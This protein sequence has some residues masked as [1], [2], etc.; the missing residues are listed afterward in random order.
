MIRTILG[1]SA[2]VTDKFRAAKPVKMS[3]LILLVELDMV[4]LCRW[5][6]VYTRL[7]NSFMN[8]GAE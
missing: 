4:I 3:L 6:T 2:A 5:K 7:K 1:C 8:S